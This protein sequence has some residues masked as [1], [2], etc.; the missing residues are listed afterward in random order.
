[1]ARSRSTKTR[2]IGRKWR[3]WCIFYASAISHGYLRRLV[4]FRHHHCLS[5][6]AT[7]TYRDWFRGR[8]RRAEEKLRELLNSSR[9][10]ISVN[11]LPQTRKRKI[12][13]VHRESSLRNFSAWPWLRGPALCIP[14]ARD[15]SGDQTLPRK[16]AF[17]QMLYCYVLR[18]VPEMV[19]ARADKC[20]CSRNM[21]ELL[22]NLPQPKERSEVSE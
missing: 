6:E 13:L 5:F 19:I 4:F 12:K 10:V 7:E 15:A 9:G 2:F 11:S 18:Y 14:I 8:F 1:M 21:S 17:P 3:R 20:N 22:I 16:I